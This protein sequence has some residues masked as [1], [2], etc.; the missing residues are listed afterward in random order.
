MV[1]QAA[2]QTY[3]A[4]TLP[5]IPILAV[6]TQH[7]AILTTDGEVKILPHAQAQTMIHKKPV[8]VCHA[9][10][11]RHRLGA[12]D[13]LA[14]DLLELFAFVHPAAFC[15]PTPV[16]LARALGLSTPQDFEDYPLALMEAAQ[17]MLSDIQKEERKDK[18]AS[19]LEIAKAMGQNGQGWPWAPYVCAAL[20]EEYN[21]DLPVMSKIALNVWKHMPEWSEQAPEPPPTHH[22]VTGEESR[23]RLAQMLGPGAERRNAQE[24]YATK[25]TAAFA[26]RADEHKTHIVLAEAGTGV[27]K[28]LGYL[29]PASVWAEKNKGTVWISTYTKNLQ[30]QI[31]QE[32]TRLFPH[33]DVKDAKVTIRKGRENYLC[34]LNMEDTIAGA[35]L[36]KDTRQMIAA[37]IM[38]RWA[39]ASRDGDL[40][41]GDFPGWLSGLLGYQYTAGLADKRGE[42]I[43]SACDHYHKCFVEKAIRKSQHAEIVVANHALVLIQTALAGANDRLP[44]R[45]VFD[46]GHH[47]FD[48][49]D[50]AFAGHLTAKETQDL[51]RWIRGAEGG[52]RSRARGLK[53]RAEDLIAG[54]AE[55][56]ADLEAIL[57]EA[58][59][60]PAQGWSRRLKDGAPDGPM[61]KFLALVYQQVF[62]RAQGRDGPYSLE[63]HTQPLIDGMQDAAGTLKSRLRALQK[64]MRDLSGRLKKRLNEQAETLDSDTRKRLESVAAGLDRR[65]END[66]ASWIAMLE[67]LAQK[68]PAAGFIDWMEIERIEGKAI[69]IGMYRHYIDPMKP[70]AAALKPH[71]H[72]IAITSATLRDGTEDEAENWRVA[73]ERTGVDFLNEDP[74]AFAEQSPFNYADQTKIFVINDVRKDDLNQV[75]AAY[76]ELFKASGGGALGLFTAISRLRAVRGAIAEP[77][78]QQGLALYA[79][80]FDEMDTGTLVDIFRE[81]I[82]ACLLGT[83]AVRDGVDVPGESLRLLVYDR[84]PW[85]RPTILHKARRDA[86][87]GRRYDELMTRLKLRQAYGR[88]VRRSSD[89]GVFVMLD[90]MLPTRLCGA[91]PEGVEVQRIGLAD[92]IKE[93]KNFLQD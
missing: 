43:F 90:S 33:P 65:S 1:T 84:V 71:A 39:E 40:Q 47:L 82:H 42:C 29:S 38:A 34:L 88:L 80:H 55:A 46:E 67:T 28:T 24:E 4:V 92:A 3:P 75:S 41:G 62:A 30:R 21:A 8:M 27:G 50:S 32:L 59:S 17:A 91:F 48:A 44:E 78:E 7:A 35:A 51:R 86:F 9:P 57:Y 87:G 26:P 23:A 6:N 22:P 5:D 61:E 89:H 11:T 14:F 53:R 36:A 60:L 10:Y 52:K 18:K 73:R 76:R 54:D 16:G 74:V 83:D 81:D 20:G 64:P 56:C 49:A 45:Y 68:E 69:D 19:P 37:G 2:S 25:M 79:Q 85:P 93:I 70:F 31:D 15:V 58:R 12:Q 72:G 77:L 13:L 63:T 66:V